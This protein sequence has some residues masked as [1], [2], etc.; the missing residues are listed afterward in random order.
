M[1]MM[2][3]VPEEVAA[4]VVTETGLL[5]QAVRRARLLRCAM[6]GLNA[7]QAARVVGCSTATARQVYAD[8]VFRNRVQQEQERVLG[9]VDS[10]FAERQLTLH[11]R[12]E[13]KA[14]DAF[15]L[16]EGL[17]EDEQTPIHLRT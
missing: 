1:P 11:E 17:M 4:G 13:R 5:T 14:L 10:A 2:T 3:Y 7:T 12:I 15:K 8:Q 16:L 9:V 6:R